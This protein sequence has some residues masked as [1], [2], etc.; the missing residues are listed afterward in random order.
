M[1]LGCVWS[2]RI[3]GVTSEIGGVINLSC[4]FFFAWPCRILPYA[5]VEW[6]STRLKCTPIHTSL[7]L[8]LC[9]PASAL[10]LLSPNDGKLGLSEFHFLLLNSAR[11]PDSLWITLSCIKFW[12]LS[13]GRNLGDHRSHL[14]CFSSLRDLS[15][16]PIKPL[17]GTHRQIAAQHSPGCCCM[18][19]ALSILPI[20]PW[21]DTDPVI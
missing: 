8:F 5:C 7:K 17:G 16:E 4:K 13:P 1:I 12:K 21:D 20:H 14:V 9:V 3:V 2:L 10:R 6:H 15:S 18:G 19:N 11:L